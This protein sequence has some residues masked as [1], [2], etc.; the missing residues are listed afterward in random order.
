MR[1]EINCLRQWINF[2]LQLRC[3]ASLTHYEA[4][5]A[6]QVCYFVNSG[7]EAN[8]LALL[9]ARLYT[10]NK[11]IVALRN[12]YHGVSLGTMATCGHS[13]WRHDLGT[14]GVLHAMNPDG[15]RGAFGSDADAYAADMEDLIRRVSR[16]LAAQLLFTFYTSPFSRPSLN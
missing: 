10:G 1:L 12:A 15:Y 13:T 5:S 11:D 3:G 7:S 16:R 6:E 9:M 8:D 14:A 4:V 2:Y